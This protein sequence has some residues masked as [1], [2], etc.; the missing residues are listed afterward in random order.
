MKKVL[1]LTGLMFSLLAVLNRGNAQITLFSLTNGA[2]DGFSTKLMTVKIV[3]P[4]NCK[5]YDL[6]EIG[7]WT[8]STSAAG[9]VVLAIYDQDGTNLF[10]TDP[11][12]A[13]AG[14]NYISESI[15]TGTILTDPG[16]DLY[17]SI[18]TSTDAVKFKMSSTNPPP[19]FNGIVSCNGFIYRHIATYPTVPTNVT[20]F[21][22]DAQSGGSIGFV[23]KGNEVSLVDVSTST[24]NFTI[25]ANATGATYQ[26]I[27]CAN[28]QPISGESNQSFTATSNGSYAVIVTQN[29]CSDTS[30]CVSFNT[31]GLE[32]NSLQLS[33]YPNPTNEKL[34]IEAGETI[35]KIVIYDLTG[36]QVVEQSI[37]ANVTTISVDQLTKGIYTLQVFGAQKSNTLRFV[38]E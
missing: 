3:F 10:A 11:L 37:Q 21:N 4:T 8:G 36:K 15:P 14:E 2:Y 29:G 12:T 27:N 23:L 26:W 24:N 18:L 31:I 22:Y 17:M 32:E 35:S 25:S 33:L 1:L 7:V 13:P 9:N 5:S 16:Q 30:E 28:N 20:Q 38:K 19:A 34:N 6:S